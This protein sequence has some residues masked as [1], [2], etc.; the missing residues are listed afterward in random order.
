MR[1]FEGHSGSVSSISLSL[2]AAF[3]LSGSS[4]QTTKIWEMASGRCLRTFEGHTSGVNSVGLSAQGKF[5]LTGAGDR[6]VRVWIL[7][8]ELESR[9]PVDWD[10]GA[11]N[12]LQTFLI[13]QTPYAG[14]LPDDREPT[15]EEITMA[16]TR[17]GKARWSESDFQRLLYT[18]G[19]AGYGWLRPEGDVNAI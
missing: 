5:A 19:C 7:D 12:Y 8:W 15:D 2:N 10:E 16:L 14:S 18:L 13:Q 3:G 1:T 11:R 4:D 9:Q 17:Q 6:T